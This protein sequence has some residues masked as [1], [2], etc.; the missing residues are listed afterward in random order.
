MDVIKY[1]GRLYLSLKYASETFAI[2]KATLYRWANKDQV[3]LLNRNFIDKCRKA[4]MVIRSS[5]YIE[6]ISLKKKHTESHLR[7]KKGE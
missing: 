2:S 6:A 7:V 4:G 3:V 5:Y 1:E